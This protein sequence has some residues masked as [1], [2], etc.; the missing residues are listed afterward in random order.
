VVLDV[1][2]VSR[3]QDT[4]FLRERE[5]CCLEYIERLKCRMEITAVKPFPALAGQPPAGRKTCLQVCI[6]D[7]EPVKSAFA[8]LS[9]KVTKKGQSPAT[10]RTTNVREGS[11]NMAA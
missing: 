10:S 4:P 9:T 6:F 8:L 1:V 11:S 5:S 7:R 3:W 2:E